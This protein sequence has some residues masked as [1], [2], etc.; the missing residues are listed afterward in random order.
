MKLVDVYKAEG[1]SLILYAM[2]KE[3]TEDPQANQINISHRRLPRWGEHVEFFESKPYRFWYFIHDG[4]IAGQVYVTHRNEIGVYVNPKHR[5]RGLAKE[6]IA[7]IMTK[8]KPMHAR[9]GML[10]GV[11]IANI[12]PANENSIR[13][14]EGLGFK[15]MQQ[16]YAL[17]M[18]EC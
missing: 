2:L 14:F 13:L 5:G 17:N 6:A 16:T 12:N 9:P 11:W 15:L 3:R 10:P 8:H 1:A 4:K 18:R 7:E